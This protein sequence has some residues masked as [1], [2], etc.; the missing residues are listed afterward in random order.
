MVDFSTPNTLQPHMRVVLCG[1][2]S[3]ILL[4]IVIM[5]RIV[6]NVIILQTYRICILTVQQLVSGVNTAAM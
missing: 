2:M 5:I 1:R 6:N 3:E 4:Y